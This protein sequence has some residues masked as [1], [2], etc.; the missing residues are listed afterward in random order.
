M[1][2]EEGR[3]YTTLAAEAKLF[4][5]EVAMEVT[6]KAIQLMGGYG[7]TRDL[8]VKECSVMLRSLKSMKVLQKF[9]VW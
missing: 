6:T 9:N 5:A 4:A 8:P 7:Y 1:A 2:K 3:P